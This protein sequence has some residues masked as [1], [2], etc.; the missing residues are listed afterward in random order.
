[1]WNCFWENSCFFWIHF[2][3]LKTI[4]SKSSIIQKRTIFRLFVEI[5]AI[6]CLF[7]MWPYTDI[8]CPI[9]QKWSC[10]QKKRHEC[11][12]KWRKA[13]NLYECLNL[14]LFESIFKNCVPFESA[15]NQKQNQ[16]KIPIGFPWKY[17]FDSM[18]LFKITFIV[19]TR[20]RSI[21]Y[22]FYF[23]KRKGKK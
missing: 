5:N 23:R 4:Q 9:L 3:N 8:V 15:K 6:L 7:Q 12:W 16:Y 13:H 11:S 1:M 19:F 14:A 17:V 2:T 10:L 21:F 22:L 20:G 18:C